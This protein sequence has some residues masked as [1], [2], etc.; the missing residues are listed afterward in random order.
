M[1]QVTWAV[2]I[3]IYTIGSSVAIMNEIGKAVLNIGSL[4]GRLEGADPGLM[5]LAIIQPVWIMPLAEE[6]V[7]RGSL[8]A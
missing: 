5:T 7:F 6:L 2:F 1:A 8:Y 4:Y 3:V